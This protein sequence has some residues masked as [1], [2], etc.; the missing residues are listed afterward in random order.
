LGIPGNKQDIGG[1]AQTYTPEFLEL[2]RKKRYGLVNRMDETKT[3]YLI[4]MH[5]PSIIPPSAI[6]DKLAV[7]GEMP[8]Y[9][10]DVTLEEGMLLVKARLV[11][12]KVLRLTGV[13]NSFPDRFYKEFVFEKPV[14]HFEATYQGKILSILVHKSQPAEAD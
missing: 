8:D 2:E 9:S 12:E 4:K 13:I 7:S 14:S 1:G 5:F 11:D 3:H 6:G 10:Y